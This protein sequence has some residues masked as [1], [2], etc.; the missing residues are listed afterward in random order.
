[1]ASGWE[2]RFEDWV[3]DELGDTEV[4]A[5]PTFRWS[6]ELQQED[7]DTTRLHP[8]QGQHPAPTPQG[9]RFS[10]RRAPA[11]PP[12]RSSVRRRR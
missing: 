4:D 9:A 11:S 6:V 1:M 10:I 8:G 7:W 12:I 5:R 2:A 3:D